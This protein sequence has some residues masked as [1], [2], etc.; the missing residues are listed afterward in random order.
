ML[1]PGENVWKDVQRALDG[2]YPVFQVGDP[3]VHDVLPAVDVGQ[4]LVDV[5]LRFGH[6]SDGVGVVHQ[7][8]LVHLD[9][10]QPGEESVRVVR[11]N[12]SNVW[13]HDLKLTRKSRGG[14][15]SGACAPWTGSPASPAWCACRS[16]R[17]LVAH[18]R[19]RF[20]T[21]MA[22]IKVKKT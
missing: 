3:L 20:L 4:D 7:L 16:A 13:Y 18:S 5:V 21:V 22:Y 10:P 14:T 9:L 6:V 1:S 19:Q 17:S 11:K 15:S 8:A 12:H 2:V